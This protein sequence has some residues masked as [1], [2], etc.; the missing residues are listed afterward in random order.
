MVGAT[1]EGEDKYYY[2]F[3]NLYDAAFLVD[4]E[5]GIIRETN[6][7]G[8]VLLNRR[9]DEIIGMV[10]RSASFPRRRVMNTDGDLPDMLR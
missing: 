9:R 1:L 8:T 4:V 10:S 2:I 7:Q 5:K 3:E 6:L